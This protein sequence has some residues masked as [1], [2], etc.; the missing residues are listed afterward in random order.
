MATARGFANHALYMARLQLHAWADQRDAGTAQLAAVDAAFA[1]AVRLHLLDAYGW[2]LLASLRLSKL[3]DQPPHSAQELPELPPGITEP[4]EVEEC[5]ELESGG[6]LRQLRAP[7]PPGLPLRAS[8]QSLAIERGYPDI[9][10][11]RNWA[12]AL[13]DLAARMGESLDEN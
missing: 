2:F 3:P 8:R 12:D 11:Y 4:G 1:P 13:A 10:D 9:N 5:R 6:W 7:L